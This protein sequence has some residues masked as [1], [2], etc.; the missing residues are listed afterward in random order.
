MTFPHTAHEWFMLAERGL[1]RFVMIGIGLALMVTGLGLGVTM[2][3]LPMG[4]LL[5][6]TG[7]GLLLWGVLGDL[8]LEP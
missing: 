5:G 6:F 3:M 2:V 1:L 8:P 7:L 4:L